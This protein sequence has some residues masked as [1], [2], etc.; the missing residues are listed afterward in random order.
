MHT[1]PVQEIFNDMARVTD[2]I[3]PVLRNP[4]MDNL[5]LEIM[6][7]NVEKLLTQLYKMQDLLIRMEQL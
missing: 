3:G 6:I 4:H 7:G 5:T 2:R 1:P